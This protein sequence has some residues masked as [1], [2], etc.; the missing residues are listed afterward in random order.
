M[1]KLWTGHKIYPITDDVNFSSLSVT[2][3]L[4]VGLQ[5]LRMT[6]CLIIVTNCDK[7]FQNPMIFEK[8]IDQTQNTP[9][10]PVS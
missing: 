6:H 8:V 7:Y 3:T 4:D 1:K 5:V 10:N 9:Y 2:F